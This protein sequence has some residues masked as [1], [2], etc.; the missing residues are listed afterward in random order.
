[1]TRVR[2]RDYSKLTRN[3]KPIPTCFRHVLLQRS[4]GK[5]PTAKQTGVLS[6]VEQQEQF[7]GRA[8]GAARPP[9]KQGEPCPSAT[10]ACRSSAEAP[11]PT[12]AI[13]GALEPPSW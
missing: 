9:C 2:R 5:S 13:R 3:I 11:D 4:L 12:L 10:S 6:G 7:T 8:A 1:M